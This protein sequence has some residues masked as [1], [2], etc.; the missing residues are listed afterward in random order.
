V[1]G[2]FELTLG[3]YKRVADLLDSDAARLLAQHGLIRHDSWMAQKPHVWKFRAWLGAGQPKRVAGLLGEVEDIISTYNNRNGIGATHYWRYGQR[4]ITS[5]EKLY[6][7]EG[8]GK[9]QV[10]ACRR[11]ELEA[12]LTPC[13]IVPVDSFR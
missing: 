3:N 11:A 5:F 13:V 2:Q 8:A 1:S 9:A 6:Y 4:D 7:R 10:A 12:T